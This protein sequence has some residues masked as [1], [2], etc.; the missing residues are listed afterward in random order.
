MR[1]FY[2]RRSIER[3][4][5]ARLTQIDYAREMALVAVE[6][7]AAGNE[8]TLG[9]VR[10]IADPDNL[11]AEFGIVVRSDLKGARLGELLMRRIIEYQR[12]HGTKKLVATVLAANTRMLE[13]ARRLGF[14]E[15]ASDEGDGVRRIELSL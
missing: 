4:E 14:S 5:L 8:Q 3:S 11:S 10:A 1:L 15:G 13:L 12:S 9:V 2:S 6:A 7:D